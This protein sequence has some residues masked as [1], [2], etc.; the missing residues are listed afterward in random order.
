M[1]EALPESL[2]WRSSGIARVIRPI[3]KLGSRGSLPGRAPSG[4]QHL[5]DPPA[6]TAPPAPKRPRN[7]APS[8]GLGRLGLAAECLTHRLLVRRND[9]GPSSP[10]APRHLCGPAPRTPD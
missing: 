2:A 8:T 6:P 9:T 5:R 1:K 7:G 10:I 3:E 4:S